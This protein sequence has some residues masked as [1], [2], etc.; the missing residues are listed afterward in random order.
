VVQWDGTGFTSLA[1]DEWPDGTVEPFLSMRYAQ[2][3]LQDSDGDGVQEIVLTGGDAT[4]DEARRRTNP[5]DIGQNVARGPQRSRTETYTWD[6]SHYTLAQRTYDPVASQHPWFRLHDGIEAMDAGDLATAID[7]YRDG[8]SRPYPQGVPNDTID[9]TEQAAIM[10]LLRFRLLLALLLTG[11]T[12]AA[13]AHYQAVQA[14]DEMAARW[15]RVFWLAYQ[16]TG[17]LWSACDV[18]VAQEMFDQRIRFRTF[19]NQYYD[20]YAAELLCPERV[21]FSLLP[22]PNT[23]AAPTPTIPPTARAAPIPRLVSPQITLPI[24]DTLHAVTFATAQH[25]WLSDGTTLLHT[26]DGSVDWTTVFTA[27]TPIIALDFVSSGQGWSLRNGRLWQTD[28]AGTTWQPLTTPIDGTIEQIDRVDL[29]HGWIG[30]L[31]QSLWATDNGGQTWTQRP[32]PC[33]L[34]P[35]IG[36][37]RLVNQATG[38]VWQPMHLSFTSPTEGFIVC[39]NLPTTAS[40][41]N[42]FYRT[43]DGGQTWRLRSPEGSA[44]VP[45]NVLADIHAV[46]YHHVWV[47]QAVPGYAPDTLLA[48]SGDGGLT[49]ERLE[50]PHDVPEWSSVPLRGFWRQL[51]FLTPE[52]GY[53][54]MIP[55]DDPPTLLGTRDGGE[56]W[57]RAYQQ[58]GGTP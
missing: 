46:D 5:P 13:V 7:L 6:G 32:V 29:R 45:Y 37:V 15:Q 23:T 10:A 36:A 1:R 18:A 43:T 39:E 58:Q 34:T 19:T 14:E 33:D 26:T 35:D 49:W 16:E 28:D 50:I 48:R 22:N 55:P 3:S 8:L 21:P 47:I 52:R 56:S 24:T 40:Q 38:L 54:I 4:A 9:P 11:D 25:G 57:Y 2:A 44:S 51:H 12:D 17:N 41:D 53:G 27:E 30:G 42:L 31:D 20:I